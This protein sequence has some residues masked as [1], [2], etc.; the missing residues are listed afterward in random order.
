MTTAEPRIQCASHLAF[1]VRDLAVAEAFYVGLLGGRLV[2]RMDR[3][4]FLRTVPERAAQL[5]SDNSPFHIAVSFGTDAFQLDLFLKPTAVPPPVHQ[6]H[7]HF[8]FAV[9]PGDLLP[10]KQ[11]LEARGVPT[12]GPRRMGPPG[13]A[14][15]YFFD[16]FGNHLELDTMGF[17][18]AT[19]VGSPDNAKLPYEWKG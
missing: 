18:G 10:F 13:Q 11:R 15:V 1:L 2:R 12:D 17:E 19:A 16:P 7:P 8:S 14:S 9:A 3:E 5:D 6:P 4:S